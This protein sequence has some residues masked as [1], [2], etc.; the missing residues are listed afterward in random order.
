MLRIQSSPNTL[1]KKSCLVCHDKLDKDIVTL[2]CGHKY[3]YNCIFMTFKM[4]KKREC[5]L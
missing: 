1:K 2:K 5:P 4:N 3:H